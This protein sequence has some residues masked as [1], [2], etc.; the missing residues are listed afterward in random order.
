MSYLVLD[1]ETVPDLAV[2]EPK[3]PGPDRIK[4]A[5]EKPTKTDL[6]FLKLV[7]TAIEEQK[8]VHIDDL[9]KAVEI[10]ELAENVEAFQKI[11]PVLDSKR[12][13]NGPDGKPEFAPLY[14][15]RP[16]C[17]AYLLL[18]DDFTIQGAGATADDNEIALLTQWSAFLEQHR[19]KIITWGGRG[20]DLPVINLRSLRRGIVQRW[21]NK[22]YRNR[23]NEDYHL[24]LCD[25]L[26]EF[27]ATTKLSLDAVAK[28]IGLPGKYGIDGSK[29]AGLYAAGEVEKIKTYCQTDVFQT[30][31]VF[32]RLCMVRGRI[33]RDEYRNAAAG[34][35]AGIRQ[36][37][38]F[39]EFAGLID[40]VTLLL[41]A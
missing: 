39:A 1:I 19:P 13:T 35:L 36:T 34:L 32:M 25:V 10:A 37:A 3:G 7:V 30:A 17:I 14:A 9:E 40:D 29:V 16:V 4:V 2:W 23:Y 15:Q 6:T 11:N 27:G 31:F 28:T 24:D 12:I 18:G 33:S 22:D 5:K 38:E 26:A 21:Y 20:F 8:T 41:E